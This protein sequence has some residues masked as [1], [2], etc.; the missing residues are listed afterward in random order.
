M[1]AT[2]AP[3][4]EQSVTRVAAAPTADATGG[5]GPASTDELFEELRGLIHNAGGGGGGQRCLLPFAD[6]LLVWCT[7]AG[8]WMFHADTM[9]F[10]AWGGPTIKVA[11][12]A[13]LEYENDRLPT[14]LMCWVRDR[15]LPAIFVDSPLTPLHQEIAHIMLK[16]L[17]QP[18][19]IVGTRAR[20]N[21][22]HREEPCTIKR[23]R[24]R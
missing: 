7:R 13:L 11:L 14:E 8:Q 1:S 24:K 2:D 5:V 16:C 21:P 10:T 19:T 9:R 18:A 22:P 17:L 12:A 3:S 15:V 6:Q 20:H 4:P 23:H